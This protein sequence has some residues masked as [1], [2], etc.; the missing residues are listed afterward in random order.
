VMLFAC[1]VAVPA[2]ASSPVAQLSGSLFRRPTITVTQGATPEVAARITIPG[3][4]PVFA[5]WQDMVL[6]LVRLLQL[7]AGVG[8]F[9]FIFYGGIRYITSAGDP[10]A[11]DEG[12]RMIIGAIIGLVIVFISYA[13]VLLV[14]QGLSAVLG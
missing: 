14:Q 1:V 3:L 11:A 8:A 13:L 12:K 6:W 5:N 2:Q 9:A 10:K 7:I 4:G